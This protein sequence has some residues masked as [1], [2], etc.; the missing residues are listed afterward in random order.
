M[1]ECEHLESIDQN[2]VNMKHP[3]LRRAEDKKAPPLG[4][5]LVSIQDAESNLW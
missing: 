3:M 1:T 2:S 4:S 5:I